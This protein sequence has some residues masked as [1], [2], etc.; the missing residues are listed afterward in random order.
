M[1][2]NGLR[3][4]IAAAVRVV[5]EVRGAAVVFDRGGPVTS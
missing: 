1:L 4:R 2:S 5:G 3:E